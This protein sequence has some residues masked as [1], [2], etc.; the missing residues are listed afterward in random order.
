[1]FKEFYSYTFPSDYMIFESFSEAMN[2]K[3]IGKEKDKIQAF[4]RAFDTQQ[5]SY[6]TYMDYLFG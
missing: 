1:M 5:N 2:N 4:F 3:L 6:L